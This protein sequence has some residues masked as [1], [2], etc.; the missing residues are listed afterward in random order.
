MDVGGVQPFP[1]LPVH[2]NPLR[3]QVGG[4]PVVTPPV[5]GVNLLEGVPRDEWHVVP[6]AFDFVPNEE[7]QGNPHFGGS[8]PVNFSAVR[9]PCKTAT[10]E[11]MCSHVPQRPMPTI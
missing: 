5:D 1:G 11:F 10:S 3:L 8:P 4:R 2:G 6:A 7:A 9:M